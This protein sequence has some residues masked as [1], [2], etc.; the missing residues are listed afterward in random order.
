[1]GLRAMQQ[2]NNSLHSGEGQNAIYKIEKQT[3]INSI[4]PTAWKWTKQAHKA[5]DP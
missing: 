3:A 5:T 1:M 2:D 4:E